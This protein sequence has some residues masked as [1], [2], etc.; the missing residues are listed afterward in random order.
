MNF[1]LRSLTLVVSY[2]AQG[3]VDGGEVRFTHIQEVWPHA[4]NRHLGN[5]GEGLA[6]GAAKDE[7][8]HLLVNGRD[9]RV[10][11]EGLGTLVQIVDPVALPDDDLTGQNRQ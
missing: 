9:V 2:V 10:S 3:T 8:P 7:H 6:D 4:A 1:A 5:V 11:H